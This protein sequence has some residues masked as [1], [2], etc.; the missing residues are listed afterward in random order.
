MCVLTVEFI[1]HLKEGPFLERVPL[2][3]H[4]KMRIRHGRVTERLLSSSILMN[5]QRVK[6]PCRLERKAKTGRP[7]RE[8][9]AKNQK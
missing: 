9:L 8:V 1:E 4:E 5:H 7:S 2:G 3:D 6:R